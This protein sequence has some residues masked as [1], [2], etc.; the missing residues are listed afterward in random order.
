MPLLVFF[1]PLTLRPSTYPR[2]VFAGYYG[3]FLLLIHLPY[4]SSTFSFLFLIITFFHPVFFGP[5]ALRT[6]Y[7]SAHRIR[8]LLR[9]EFRLLVHLHRQHP[10][11]PLQF[12]RPPFGHARFLQRNHSFSLLHLLEREQT[13]VP[14]S[15]L[16][17]LFF[18]FFLSR[19]KRR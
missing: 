2:S 19:D 3:E 17:A 12:L 7:L 1:G 14:F 18:C 4:N 15:S 9:R 6:L 11:H 8:G 16:F 10:P 5:F 13:Y